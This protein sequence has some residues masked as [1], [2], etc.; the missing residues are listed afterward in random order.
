MTSQ[1]EV[2]LYV[3]AI[4]RKLGSSG[5]NTQ[6]SIVMQTHCLRCILTNGHTEHGS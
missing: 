5:Y 3:G 2:Y 4:S 6:L 1:T